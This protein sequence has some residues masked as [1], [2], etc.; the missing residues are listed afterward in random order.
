MQLN[1][2]MKKYYWYIIEIENEKRQEFEQYLTTIANNLKDTPYVFKAYYAAQTNGLTINYFIYE[3]VQ[4]LYSFI[5]NRYKQ[6]LISHKP[7]SSKIVEV[8][9]Y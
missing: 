5:K 1:E 2:P 3:E 4:Y 8:N 9:A 7:E 6:I